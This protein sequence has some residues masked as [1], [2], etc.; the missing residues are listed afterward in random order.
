MHK[1]NQDVE[2]A[3]PRPCSSPDW[4]GLVI[5]GN[6]RG[7]GGRAL[8]DAEG[9]SPRYARGKEAKRRGYAAYRS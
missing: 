6:C 2:R 5:K 3:T 4:G 9:L 8:E 7:D 1:D